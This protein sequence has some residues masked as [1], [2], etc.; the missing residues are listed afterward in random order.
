MR[1]TVCTN[2]DFFPFISTDVIHTYN[3]QVFDNLKKSKE[4]CHLLGTMT[5]V[6]SDFIAFYFELGEKQLSVNHWLDEI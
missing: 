5:G 2:L 1:P 4:I 3:K 6:I